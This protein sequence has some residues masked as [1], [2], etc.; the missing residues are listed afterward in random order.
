M[1]LFGRK[2]NERFS[3]TPEGSENSTGMR[4]KLFRHKRAGDSDGAVNLEAAIS[5][6]S[7]APEKYTSTTSE[8][9]KTTTVTCSGCNEEIPI[10]G[11]RY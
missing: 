10:I 1:G 11:K 6:V 7:Y 4:D 9:D 8:A 2:I 3:D 5:E